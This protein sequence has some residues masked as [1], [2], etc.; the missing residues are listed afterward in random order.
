MVGTPKL[1]GMIAF[2]TVADGLG[3]QV[4]LSSNGKLNIFQSKAQLQS[5]HEDFILVVIII[6][7][8]NKKTN[9]NFCT[10]RNQFAPK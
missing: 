2:E 10:L 1:R 8:K 5:S 7:T 3:P 4:W 9:N 6:K